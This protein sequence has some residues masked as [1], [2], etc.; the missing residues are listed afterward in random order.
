M[1]R[2]EQMNEQESGFLQQAYRVADSLKEAGEAAWDKISGFA[3]ARY[4]RFRDDTP[5]EE[6]PSKIVEQGPQAPPVKPPVEGGPSGV[7][8][9]ASA[10]PPEESDVAPAVIDE[11][12]DDVE[13]IAPVGSGMAKEMLR[14]AQGE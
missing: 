9:V 14:R 13:R 1:E 6:A 11:E 7:D 2:H 4:E 8:I 3:R 12:T 10:A 5:A